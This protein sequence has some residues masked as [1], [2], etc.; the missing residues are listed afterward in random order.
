[1]LARYAEGR[2]AIDASTGVGLPTAREGDLDIIWNVPGVPGLQFR[3]R[4]AYVAESRNRVLRAFRIIL[5]YEVP[6]L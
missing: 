3:F 2:D 1:V 4:N 6:L 5:N